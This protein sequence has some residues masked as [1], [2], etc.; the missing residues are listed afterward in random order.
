MF[1]VR[2]VNAA[3]LSQFS[4]ESEPVE[5]KAAIGEWNYA[6]TMLILKQEAKIS[7]RGAPVTL[8]KWNLSFLVTPYTVSICAATLPPPWFLCHPV[9]LLCTVMCLPLHLPVQPR[10]PQPSPLSP[11]LR[12][13]RQGQGQDL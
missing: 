7:L 9:P 13:L 11:T 5:V 3:G 6:G 1:R 2:A 10:K 4:P 12:R 8:F